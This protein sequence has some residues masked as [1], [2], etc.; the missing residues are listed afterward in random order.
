VIAQAFERGFSTRRSKSGGMGL[1]WSA[2]A[3]RAMGG[4]LSL[5]SVGMGMGA[6]ARLR[7][8]LP[9]SSTAGIAQ[10]LAA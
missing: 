8:P 1:H 3:A 5:H 7:L 6:T 2:N 9:P 10:Q 4:A